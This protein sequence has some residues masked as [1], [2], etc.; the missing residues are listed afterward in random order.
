MCIR[1]R[2]NALSMCTLDSSSFTGV[3]KFLRSEAAKGV[4]FCRQRLSVQKGLPA[5]V[6]KSSYARASISASLP[7][8]CPPVPLSRVPQSFLLRSQ[9]IAAYA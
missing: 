5:R 1:D 3:R 2:G 4:Q 7:W 9:D 6:V 8:V